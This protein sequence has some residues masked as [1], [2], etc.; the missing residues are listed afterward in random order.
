L[1]SLNTQVIRTRFEQANMPGAVRMIDFLTSEKGSGVLEI[2]SSSIGPN[3]MGRLYLG[4][5]PSKKFPQRQVR[6]P[7]EDLLNMSLKL[8]SYKPD[9]LVYVDKVLGEMARA[10]TSPN[11]RPLT[12]E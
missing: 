2:G 10:A 7:I 5:P 6:K 1:E 3:G 8:S 12:F 4:N 9:E 11:K